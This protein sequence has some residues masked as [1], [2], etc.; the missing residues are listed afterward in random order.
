MTE[1][2]RGPQ[3]YCPALSLLR[4]LLRPVVHPTVCPPYC[5]IVL[6]TTMLFALPNA[7]GCL[8]LSSSFYASVTDMHRVFYSLRPGSKI[9][10]QSSGS[11]E[12]N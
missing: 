8:C 7:V 12:T 3:R 11:S 6:S 10:E 9:V 2:S 4:L 5:V 1:V